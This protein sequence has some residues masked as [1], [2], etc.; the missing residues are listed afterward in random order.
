[1]IYITF[2][3]KLW[4][5]QQQGEALL[6]QLPKWAREE[7]IVIE[8]KADGNPTKDQ[9]RLM[10]QSLL[11]DR[12]K[13]TLHFERRQTPVFALALA[14]PGRLGPKLRPHAEGPPCD[15]QV[16]PLVPG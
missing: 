5:T 16:P 12:F 1:M 10:V 2:A 7:S 15:A 6:A 9:M 14:K 11:A 8:A 13:L 4:P 3:Y